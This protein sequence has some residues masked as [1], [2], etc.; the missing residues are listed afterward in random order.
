MSKARS[1]NSQGQG[2]WSQEGWNT[3]SHTLICDA[4][5]PG[6]VVPSAEP[7]EAVVVAV[8]R[9]VVVAVD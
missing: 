4:P 5:S 1:R 2:D 3:L 8:V 6:G 7:G 9:L